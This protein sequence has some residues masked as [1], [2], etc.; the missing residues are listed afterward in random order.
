MKTWDLVFLTKANIWTNHPAVGS[1]LVYFKGID[2]QLP[3]G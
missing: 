2:C 1:E 3:L